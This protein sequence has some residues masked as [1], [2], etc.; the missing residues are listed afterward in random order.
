MLH[1]DR[2]AWIPSST[3]LPT[4]TNTCHMTAWSRTFNSC[5]RRVSALFALASP[6]GDCGSLRMGTSISP[7]WTVCQIGLSLSS[8]LP[9]SLV[10]NQAIQE[11]R[12]AFLR[13]LSCERLIKFLKAD[14]SIPIF[15]IEDR[16]TLRIAHDPYGS[17]FRLRVGDFEPL[18]RPSRRAR[19][20]MPS[21]LDRTRA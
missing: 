7:G 16:I 3:A 14:L 6:V 2:T 12:S 13:T 18:A 5:S 17:R 19:P 9:E 4:I 20:A 21:Q 11:K 8:P 10:P 1:S 15:R